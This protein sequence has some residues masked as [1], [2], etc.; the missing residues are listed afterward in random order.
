[1]RWFRPCVPE[2]IEYP[3]I[4]PVPEGV[5]RPFWSVMIPTYNCAEYLKRTLESV[6][7]QDP[8]AKEMQI[9][10]VDDCS[11]KD[12]PKSVVDTL[13]RGRVVFF[14]QAQN[15]GATR[16]FNTCIQR[17]RGH[18]V[19]I[20]H[21]DDMVMANFYDTYRS[22]IERHAETRMVCGRAIVIDEGDNWQGVTSPP[23]GI[24]ISTVLQGASDKLLK[25]NFLATPTVVVSR[26]LYEK[27]GGFAL[28]LFH[29]ADWEMWMRLAEHYQVGYVH[30]PHSLYR[31]HEESDTRLLMT[32]GRN[33][34]DCL[35]AIEI[36]LQRM[37]PETRGR[38]RRDGHRYLSGCATTSAW[39]CHSRHAYSAALHHSICALRLYPSLANAYRLLRSLYRAFG[40]GLRGH[41]R[42]GRG[43]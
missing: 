9:E 39:I 36:Q 28:C 18:W 14:R 23:P 38:R 19:H 7:D 11:A 16:N 37:P 35:R 22:F 17:A 20:L 6:L 5:H 13:G 8:G 12:D 33:I 27:V 31:V 2:P 4:D 30:H 21:G 41:L 29:A 42:T 15:V 25:G 32:R 10:V 24:N 1:M 3:R 34:E 26:E 40:A 43:S